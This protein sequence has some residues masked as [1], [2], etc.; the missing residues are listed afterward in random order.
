MAGSLEE[1]GFIFIE[2]ECSAG[3]LL[4]HGVR[5]RTD[6]EQMLRRVASGDLHLAMP[7]CL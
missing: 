1:R 5:Y 4:D 3:R 7:S 6:Y 2:C